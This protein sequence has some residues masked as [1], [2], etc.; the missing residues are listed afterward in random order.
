MRLNSWALSG[1]WTIGVA[2][3][4]VGH[5]GIGDEHDDGGAEG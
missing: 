5:R 3:A 4:P 2:T 1:D